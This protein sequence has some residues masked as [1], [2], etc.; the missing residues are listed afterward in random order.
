MAYGDG[1]GEGLFV[2]WPSP[3][4]EETPYVT[5]PT[6]PNSILHFLCKVEPLKAIHGGRERGVQ[7]PEA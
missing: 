4:Q 7:E 2:Q 6:A 3:F 1:E 5:A